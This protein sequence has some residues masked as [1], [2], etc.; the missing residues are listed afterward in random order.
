MR[1]LLLL[2]TLAL[3]PVTFAATPTVG[4]SLNPLTVTASVGGAS[5]AYQPCNNDQ[6]GI[7][8]FAKHFLPGGVLE[9]HGNIVY[10][11]LGL[12]FW[13][14]PGSLEY[15]AFKEHFEPSP[16]FSNIQGPPGNAFPLR[17]YSGTLPAPLSPTISKTEFISKMMGAGAQLVQRKGS[18]Y[19]FVTATLPT[20]DAD[21]TAL[22]TA[23]SSKLEQYNFTCK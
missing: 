3:T 5:K 11:P 15:Q 10:S 8:A 16:S 17:P 9:A 12:V 18:N 21:V 13:E 19:T 14:T 22:F 2:L 4:I 1:T 20:G 6:A 7:V 23:S